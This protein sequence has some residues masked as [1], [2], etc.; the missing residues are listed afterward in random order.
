MIDYIILS[1]EIKMIDHVYQCINKS[2]IVFGLNFDP[3]IRNGIVI[4]YVSECRGLRITIRGQELIIQNSLCKFYHGYNHINFTYTELLRTKTYLEE[5]LG[6][7]LE[8]AKV[9]SFEYGVMINVLKPSLVFDILGMYKNRKPQ[10]MSYKGKVYGVFYENSTHKIKIY[11]KTLEAKRNNF[12]LD[13]GLL[14]I[15]KKASKTHLN[16]SPRFV[17][18]QIYTFGDI[19]KR[20]T[21]QLL[22]DDLI[23][24]LCRIELNDVTYYKEDL[25]IK[26]LRILGYMQNYPVRGLVK[27][28][29]KKSYE[30]DQ[31]RFREILSD[32][33]QNNFDNFIMSVIEVI[34]KVIIN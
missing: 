16:S 33:N 30:E 31:K 29:H 2:F 23:Q 28:Y 24:S 8:D 6:M 34:D 19:C 11:D 15:E 9:K 21:F 22:G 17:D 26:D 4:K 25:T 7:S 1:V 18:N 20:K 27:Q 12:N 3:E 5:F 13:F 10:E 14:R 32:K